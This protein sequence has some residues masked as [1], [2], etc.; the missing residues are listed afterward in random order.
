MCD[1]DSVGQLEGLPH[2]QPETAAEIL[3]DKTG[4]KLSPHSFSK[5]DS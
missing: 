5:I 2:K 1:K 3:A 4:V